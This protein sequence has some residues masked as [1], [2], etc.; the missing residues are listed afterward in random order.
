MR[1]T[2]HVRKLWLL[3]AALVLAFGFAQPASADLQELSVERIEVETDFGPFDFP[4]WYM[5]SKSLM[6]QACLDNPDFCLQ[7]L[8]EPP[9][10]GEEPVLEGLE[11]IYW[12]AETQIV[13]PQVPGS[14]DAGRAR[15]IFALEAFAEVDPDIGPDP[16]VG[17]FNAAIIRLR[18]L[19]PLASYTIFHPFA[20]DGIVVQSDDGGRLNYED[21][22]LHPEGDAETLFLSALTVGPVQH[23][24]Y[25]D[26]LL[27]IE[28]PLESGIFYIGNP[29]VIDP[30]GHTVFGSPFG[31]NFVRVE[32]P[33][34]PGGFIESDKFSV[35]GQ[36][37]YGDGQN[38]APIANFDVAKTKLGMPVLIDVLDNDLM[39]GDVPINPTS[40][41]RGAAI[42]NLVGGT[43]AT[44]RDLDKVLLQFTPTAAGA[45]GFDY[46]VQ[47]F[48]G[49]SDTASVTVLVENLLVNQAEYRAP[50]GKW[51]LNGT[52]NFRDL[53][54]ESETSTIYL[55]GLFGA[56]EVPPVT[57]SGSGETMITVRIDDILGPVID[58][59][60]TYEGLVGVTQAHIH[61]GGVG[62]NG[63]F[64]VFLCTNLAL[65]G[66]FPDQAQTPQACPAAAGTVTGTLS[67]DDF[68]S[69]GAVT[70]FGEL[71]QAIDDGNTYVNVHTA[72][73]GPGEIRGQIGRNVIS[74]RAGEN[75]PAIGAAEVQSG[76]GPNL[77]WSYSGKSIGSPGAAPHMIH[78]ESAL[79]NVET[80]DLQLR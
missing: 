6:L 51:T 26:T 8:E 44:E 62:V 78:A 61:N 43:V 41:E 35:G 48:T 54:V 60:L 70:T 3:V 7:E 11:F 40:L 67:E 49:M 71:L 65:P 19:Q 58:Y 25:S 72:A 21:P 38:L 53:V 13:Y 30:E 55:T 47:S 63:P 29:T 23:F 9:A 5:D 37:F 79:G 46:T 36:I 10:N 24:L 50:T 66:N 45:V 39:Q 17:V 34:L 14:S 73:F 75:G 16:T 12:A 27:P 18:G 28:E 59:S 56:Q 20:A 4:L 57:S 15:F 69:A 22:L 32:G 42:T 31:R 80:L 1:I 74:L 76:T 2:K 68:I 52:S 64:N 77:T 33:G